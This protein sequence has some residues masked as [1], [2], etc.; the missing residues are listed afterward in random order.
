MLP[1]SRE[2]GMSKDITSVTIIAHYFPAVIL[3]DGI[4]GVYHGPHYWAANLSDIIY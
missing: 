4:V 2:V 3:R 1:I